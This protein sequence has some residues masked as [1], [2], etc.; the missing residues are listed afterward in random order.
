MEC[1]AWPTRGREWGEG[2]GTFWDETQ[3]GPGPAT[4][5]DGED[6]P[7]GE[8]RHRLLEDRVVQVRVEGRTHTHRMETVNTKMTS[9]LIQYVLESEAELSRGDFRGDSLS[10]NFQLFE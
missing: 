3:S 1:F 5:D 4:L 9:M 10:D 8:T 7:G 6:D 2:G